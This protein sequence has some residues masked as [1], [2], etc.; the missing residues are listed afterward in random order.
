[1]MELDLGGYVFGE[2]GLLRQALTHSSFVYEN[3]RSGEI[4]NERL[5]FLGDAV[6]ELLI[7]EMLYKR[8]PRLSEGKLS[9]ARASLV[10]ESSLSV[11]ARRLGLGELVR[12]G[13]GETANGGTEKDSILS[14]VLEAI[15]GAMYLDGGIEEARRFVAGMFDEQLNIARIE[16]S[17]PISDPKSSLQEIIQK[18]SRTPLVYTIIREE[19]PAHLK[20]FTIT[21]SHEGRTLGTGYGNKKK[22]AERQAA[23]E[24]L[25]RIKR[26]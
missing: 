1:M 4:S 18:R 13:R 8:F 19:G 6:L 23:Q 11:H 7:S 3:S 24:A 20:E 17:G 12:L 21:V 26:Y 10:C 25:K 16:S 9:K 2:P 5:E 22:D 15:I 14:D